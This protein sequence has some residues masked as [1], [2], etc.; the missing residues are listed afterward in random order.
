LTD[1]TERIEALGRSVI[2]YDGRCVSHVSDALFEA[3]HWKD[4]EQVPGYSG[5][6]GAT[7]FV[8]Y[9]EQQW[10]LRHYHRGGVMR[11]LVR[12]HFLGFRYTRSRSFREWA[13]LRAIQADGLPAPE[14]IAARFVRCGATY[15]A[16]L[17]TRRLPG[18]EPLSRRL[19]REV[20]SPAAWNSVGACIGRFHA[21][22]YFHADLTAHNIQID[23]TDNVFLLECDR[24]RRL[25]PERAWQNRNLDRLKRSFNKLCAQGEI[26]FDGNCWSDISAGYADVAGWLPSPLE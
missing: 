10:V 2:V 24:G 22:G 16:D 6:R 19:S 12:D 20:P 8:Q 4:A 17:I 3:S 13:L 15:T 23:T 1:A 7:L 5:G 9:G 14:P 26:S 21:A 25:K 11:H 18:V